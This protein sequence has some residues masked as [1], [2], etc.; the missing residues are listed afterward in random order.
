[1]FTDKKPHQQK[2]TGHRMLSNYQL[3]CISHYRPIEHIHK[4]IYI[5]LLYPHNPRKCKCIY[6]YPYYISVCYHI[7]IC[8]YV[9]FCFIIYGYI[10]S[11]F[12]MV[13]LSSNNTRSSSLQASQ[14]EVARKVRTP[15]TKSCR[16]ALF[17]WMKREYYSY[18]AKM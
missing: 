9:T 11:P 8:M 15:R 18:I 12:N 2:H 5:P 1:M 10:I 14:A 16:K 13:N 17:R 3:N 6:T 7:Y 4:S